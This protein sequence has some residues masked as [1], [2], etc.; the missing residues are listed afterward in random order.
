MIER[1]CNIA[2][3]WPVHIS[4]ASSISLRYKTSHSEREIRLKRHSIILQAV[5][6]AIIAEMFRTLGMRCRGL[7]DVC[8]CR[9]R[10]FVEEL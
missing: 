10:F 5:W 6:S 3:Q 9:W 7:F 2:M 4:S 1:N 8:H